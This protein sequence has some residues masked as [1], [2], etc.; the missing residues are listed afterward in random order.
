M[1]KAL[2]ALVVTSLLV[3]VGSF[4]GCEPTELLE[5][6]QQGSDRYVSS[7][8]SLDDAASYDATIDAN[9]SILPQRGPGTILVASFNIQ[10]FGQS[11]KNKPDVMQRLAEVVRQFDVVAIQEIR[12]KEQTLLP[13]FMRY[14]N[15]DGAAYDFILSERLGQSSSQEQYAYVFDSRRI[16]ADKSA[17]YLVEDGSPGGSSTQTVGTDGMQDL[18]HREPYV[19]R[20]VVNLPARDNPFRFTM[21]NMH[22][23]PDVVDQ[24]LDVL[25]NVFV[26]VRNYEYSIGEDDLILAGDLN[27]SPRQFGRL[28]QI[29]D[30]VPIIQEGAYTNVI[31]TK[32]YDNL[33]IDSQ[34]TRE[35]TGRHGVLNLQQFF[36]L[37]LSDAKRLS[38]HYPVWAEFTVQEASGNYNPQMAGRP[39]SMR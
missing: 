17:A 36:S 25:A 39:I 10:T 5:Q 19:A 9:Y 2:T 37:S 20:F 33:L 18:L 27:A 31:Q 15:S 8:N 32:L 26:A 1:Q 28:G 12:E 22:T 13:E 24:E 6:I 35:F 7:D 30:V 23:D 4:V 21:M 3:A 16:L 29:T 34:M 11:K 38:D 14:I